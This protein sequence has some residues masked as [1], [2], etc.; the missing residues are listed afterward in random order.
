MTIRDRQ[1]TGARPDSEPDAGGSTCGGLCPNPGAI[2]MK[3]RLILL[4]LSLQAFLSAIVGGYLYYSA[5][6]E[7]AF[8]EAEQQMASRVEIINKSLTALL[9]E[10]IK[11]VVTLAGMRD[12]R[13]ALVWTERDSLARANAVLDHFQ[14]SLEADVCY[15]M[16]RHGRT[17]AS[18]NRNSPQ[19]FIGNNF[20]FRPYFQQAMAGTPSAYLAMGTT[21]GTRGAYYSA[22]VYAD[23]HEDP[24]GT[25]V[26]K[27]AMDQIEKEMGLGPDETV[28]ISDPQGIIFI[29]NKKELLFKPLLPLSQNER[30]RISQS[31]QFGT[32]PWE[33]AGFR[34]VERR[35]ARDSDG[36]R[37]LMHRKPLKLFPGWEMIHLLSVVDIA[38][39]VSAPLI[40]ITGPI[41]LFLCVMVG[42]SVLFFYRKAS[43]E[44]R[45]RRAVEKA[46]RQSEE[47]YRSLYHNTPAMLHSIDV[48]GRLVSVSDH[49]AEVLGYSRKEVIGRP[50]VDFFDP[51][52]RQHAETV[53]FKQFF[54]TGHCVDIPYRF[55]T[56][57]GREI[58]VLL[59]AIADR[60]EKGTITRSL[61][62]SVDVTDR[63]QAEEALHQAKEELSLYSKG[64]E[65]LVA[66]RTREI[67]NIFRY[68]PAVVYMKDTNGGY[69][70][71][72]SRFEEL[73]GVRND[74][75][76]GKLDAD[77]LPPDVAEQFRENE[78]QVI[79]QARYCQ[80]EEEIQLADGRHTFLSVKFPIY[81]DVGEVSG[82]CSI[83]TDIT[84][85]KKAR[86]R[87]KRLS[88]SIMENQEKERQALARE[89]HDELGQV[90]TALRMDAVWLHD[91]MRDL[92]AKSADRALTMCELIDTTIKEVRGLAI[93]LRPGVL[94]DLGLVD[95]L[96][97]YTADF[98]RRTKITC[99][100]DHRN[101]PALNNTVA[102]A[103][104]RISQE[105]LTN[106]ARHAEATRT[107]VLLVYDDH[108]LNLEI[109]DDGKGMASGS[110]DDMEGL[111]LAGMRERA[112]LAGGRLEMS[113]PFQGGLKITCRIPL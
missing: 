3:L 26:I 80:V 15:L 5:L 90:L 113:R 21:S 34:F 51:T 62:V 36:R 73:F 59:S 100:F 109:I 70:V 65:R 39:K 81:D 54:E 83:S 96:E 99:T 94:D 55:I 87:L 52:S 17:I 6:K 98:E 64:L 50:L 22:P 1:A 103:V 23:P 77:V 43:I 18:S 28:L 61:A 67:T 12:M 2:P 10:N 13:G 101:I 35:Y 68:I 95:A 85:L 93:R 58:D 79:D 86:D 108:Q 30:R 74:A 78:K 41:V 84:A 72:N 32:G 8:K 40:R 82:V 53:V 91:R 29:S 107:G 88:G 111:G 27:V 97:W 16:N 38:R 33:P 47:R 63:K 7:A 76:K 45:E 112:E 46:L 60:D 56:R 31:R 110:P 69:A 89:L 75:I 104:Y 42:L 49:W 102:T 14:T 48:D 71:V 9:S 19:S 105:A 24:V 44:I 106:A 37:Y 25:V 92:D 57:H 4:V 20:H 11:P 66:K